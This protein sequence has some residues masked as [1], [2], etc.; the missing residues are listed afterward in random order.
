MTGITEPTIDDLLAQNV[1]AL[2]A[3]RA[4]L[5]P[6]LAQSDAVGT[7]FDDIFLLRYILSFTKEQKAVADAA[8]PLH[9]CLRWRM[10]NPKL[11][12][13]ARVWD[14]G[15]HSAS[16]ALVPSIESILPNLNGR[17]HRKTAKDGGP[18]YLIRGCLQ[19]DKAMRA[20]V[21]TYGTDGLITYMLIQRER[22]FVIN[23]A[24]T[25]K[26]RRLVKM[27]QLYDM[28]DMAFSF[29]RQ[30]LKIFGGISRLSEQYYPQLM[31]Q[32]IIFNSPSMVRGLLALARPF[33]PAKLIEKLKFCKGQDTH[34]TTA[35]IAGCPF[36]T[37]VID[38]ESIPTFLGGQCNCSGGCVGHPN[39]M[40]AAAPRLGP[41]GRRRRAKV[42]A[43]ATL[44]LLFDLPA[45]AQISWELELE[46]NSAQFIG[47]S[48]VQYDAAGAACS[49]GDG[50]V[51]VAARE[52][53]SAAPLS[54]SVGPFSFRCDLELQL[55]NSSST[56]VQ[57]S[58]KVVLYSVHVTQADA[59]P[60]AA[61]GDGIAADEDEDDGRE[62]Y[63]ALAEQEW[64]V[65][66]ASTA[67]L[68]EAAGT[69]VRRPM[70][71]SSR[72]CC[73]SRQ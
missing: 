12:Q 22:A 7:L 20:H 18:V 29:D 52:L 42:A 63:D 70:R 50:H 43:K 55:D 44:P 48:C 72:G 5:A 1:E 3:L 39:S 36:A 59:P 47:V 69:R 25:R 51:L 11:L 17:L 9:Q 30:M 32:L 4:E 37:R 66:T 61:L 35:A 49:T 71:R 60:A 13:A 45:G 41:D 21:D 16:L 65:T 54:L 31:R 56:G 40:R 73:S 15:D 67:T 28:G 58:K 38:L 27:I 34:L 26:T 53:G 14:D 24:Q 68:H 46:C 8:E 10:A 6:E 62:F 57:S 33:F 19:D 2:R 23:D 64:S